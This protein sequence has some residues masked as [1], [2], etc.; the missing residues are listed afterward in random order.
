[1]PGALVVNHT[2]A[3]EAACLAGLGLIQAPRLGLPLR[4]SSLSL[5]DLRAADGMFI[6]NARIGVVPV[7]RVREHV[8]GMTGV[9]QLSAQRLRDA[10][11][12]LDA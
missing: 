10:I 6:T 12:A 11:E 5:D 9:A 3:Y 1:M 2:D 8:F 7:R 4:E